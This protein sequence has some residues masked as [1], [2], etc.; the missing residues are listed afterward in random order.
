[1]HKRQFLYKYL[2]IITI[3]TFDQKDRKCI[4]TTTFYLKQ[5]GGRIDCFGRLTVL[6]VQ[7]NVFGEVNLDRG[8]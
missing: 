6:I 2:R 8:I 1:M 5:F 4:S 3:V 7:L